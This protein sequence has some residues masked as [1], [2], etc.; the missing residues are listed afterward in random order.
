MKLPAALLVTGLAMPPL[1]MSQTHVIDAPVVGVQ[2]VVQ[3]VRERIPYEV[4]REEQVRVADQRWGNAVV[5]SV[6]GGLLGGAAGN[7]LGRNSSSRDVITGAGAVLGATVGYQRSQ[8]RNR[9]EAYYVTENV[10]TTEYELRE[11]ERIDG[12]RVSYRYGDS[13]YETRTD[14]DP[15]ATIPVR[16]RPEPLL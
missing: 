15:G 9:R 1:A 14:R 10:C 7:L 11:R 16:V 3:V 13:I 6:V 4:C 2:P 8:A 5:P 12:Y